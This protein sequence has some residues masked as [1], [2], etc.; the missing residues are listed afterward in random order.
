MFKLYEAQ[1]VG[2][3]ALGIQL[4]CLLCI[5]VECENLFYVFNVFLCLEINPKKIVCTQTSR[6]HRHIESKY[7]R[8]NGRRMPCLHKFYCLLF[9]V[10]VIMRTILGEVIRQVQESIGRVVEY[11][12][13]CMLPLTCRR[14]SWVFHTV[15]H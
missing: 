11:G 13:M 9:V 8:I 14:L 10:A 15:P 5:Y 1:T 2:K 7:Y 6:K 4:K 12:M 3:R